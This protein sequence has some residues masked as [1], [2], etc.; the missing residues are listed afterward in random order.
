M[1]ASEQPTSRGAAPRT[2]PELLGDLVR[3]VSDLVR[4]EIRLARSEVSDAG[5]QMATGVETMGAGA[6]VLLVAL[7][8]LSQ[9]LVLALANYMEPGFAALAVGGG[10]GL[11]GA[12][13]VIVGRRAVSS[14]RLTPERTLEQT[15]RDMRL[16]KEKL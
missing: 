2:I 15:S 8:V 5:R 16:A 3:E 13:L 7:I 10:L 4:G 6:V 11:I 12:I 14:V 1:A 9:A